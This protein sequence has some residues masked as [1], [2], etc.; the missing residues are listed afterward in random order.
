MNGPERSQNTGLNEQ[1]PLAFQPAFLK[2]V[3]VPEDKPRCIGKRI[4]CQ[5]Q[6]Y[7]SEKMSNVQPIVHWH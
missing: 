3:P 4:P 2:V 5:S 6:W 7:P 1:F